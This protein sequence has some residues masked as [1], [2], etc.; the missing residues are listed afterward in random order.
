MSPDL[1]LV[2]FS[3]RLIVGPKFVRQSIGIQ[4]VGQLA[5]EEI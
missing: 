2:F 3:G 1:F 4:S 5:D